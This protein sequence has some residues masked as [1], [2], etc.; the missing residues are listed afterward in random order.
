MIFLGLD[1]SRADSFHRQDGS[2]LGPRRTR[3]VQTVYVNDV[4]VGPNFDS[5]EVRR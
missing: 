1:L 5:L 3:T 4:I 2:P